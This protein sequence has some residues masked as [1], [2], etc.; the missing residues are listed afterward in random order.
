[1]ILT[2]SPR[3]SSGENRASTTKTTPRVRQPVALVC[4]DEGRTVV[5]ANRRSGSLS[6]IDAA[7]RKVVAE[8]DVGRGLA[9]L[10]LLKGG[11]RLL[12]VDETSS[13]LLLLDYHDRAVRVM[14]RL[15]VSPGAVRLAV[16]A[17]GASC[18]VASALVAKAHIC[19]GDER[20][21]R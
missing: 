11:R 5:V 13:E 19:L 1:M 4:A 3:A 7:A 16:W 12:A 2:G 18:A 9:D 8:H 15:T 21:G 20:T 14:D 10:A 6:V 17:D